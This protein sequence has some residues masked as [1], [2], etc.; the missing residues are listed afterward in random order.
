MRIWQRVTVRM[1]IVSRHVK[2]VKYALRVYKRKK[3]KIFF[4]SKLKIE[5]RVI[6]QLYTERVKRPKDKMF[7]RATLLPNKTHEKPFRG[8]SP[9]CVFSLIF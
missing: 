2:R 1:S 7:V 3:K 5:I 6:R 9:S 4:L 8:K